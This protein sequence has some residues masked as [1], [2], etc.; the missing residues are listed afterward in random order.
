MISDMIIAFL[1]ISASIFMP[2]TL[3]ALVS[4][5]TTEVFEDAPAVSAD[6]LFVPSVTLTVVVNGPG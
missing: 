1:A 4:V 2:F 6:T 5:D 3:F